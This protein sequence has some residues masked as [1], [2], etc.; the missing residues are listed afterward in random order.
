VKQLPYVVEPP[1]FPKLAPPAAVVGAI[2]AVLG[3][4]VPASVI[5]ANTGPFLVAIGHFEPTPGVIHAKLAGASF[6]VTR[7]TEFQVQV[8]VGFVF[9]PPAG[10][11]AP[12]VGILPAGSR[13]AWSMS[14][15]APHPGRTPTTWWSTTGVR[16]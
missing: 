7:D 9:E 2:Q 16:P 14:S 8:R 1:G 15:L 10:V 4:S 5:A 6:A 13:T 11:P 3:G 12:R